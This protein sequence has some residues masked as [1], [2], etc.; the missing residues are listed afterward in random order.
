MDKPNFQIGEQ[1]VVKLWF[2]YNIC[3]IE[4]AYWCPRRKYWMYTVKQ[5][6]QLIR[7]CKQENELRDLNLKWRA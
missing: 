5:K 2:F 7:H 1:V 3:E 6:G 4:R